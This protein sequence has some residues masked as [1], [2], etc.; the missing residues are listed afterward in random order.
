[1]DDT[2]R[3][4]QTSVSIFSC[5]ASQHWFAAKR[6]TNRY[7][8]WLSIDLSFQDFQAAMDRFE[9]VYGLP[10]GCYL[11]A[12]LCGQLAG[13]VGLRKLDDDICEMKRLYVFEEFRGKGI[14]RQLCE[15]LIQRAIAFGYNRMRL[16]TLERLDSANRL[17]ERI[18]F[19]DIPPYRANPENGARYMEY[20]LSKTP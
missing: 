10:A 12:V 17:Y 7:I 5:S 4:S 2:C 15:A 18:G 9:L 1:M 20:I 11:L 6:I 13:G 8:E 3:P 16:D 19:Y 14:G